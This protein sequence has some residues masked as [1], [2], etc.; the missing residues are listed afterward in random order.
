MLALLHGYIIPA[1][2]A[3]LPAPMQSAEATA[4]LLAIA[5]QESEADARR[6]LPKGPARGFWQFEALGV[7][8]VCEHR[9]TKLMLQDALA[10]LKYSPV[11]PAAGLHLIIEHNDV[12]AAV[13]ARLNLW[14]LRPALPTREQSDEGWRQ[15]LRAWRPGKPRPQSWPANF[16][17][18]WA[19]VESEG[20]LNG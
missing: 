19:L 10:V 8:G 2:Y 7:A 4:M 13:F 9:L 18:A 12:L 17:T 15:Y 5:L 16:A 3:V 20:V 1:A 14:P 11:L 6:Q